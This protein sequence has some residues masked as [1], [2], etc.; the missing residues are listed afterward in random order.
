MAG[1]GSLALISAYESTAAANSKYLL[2]FLKYHF[3]F[4]LLLS[5][6]HTTKCQPTSPSP[7]F[8]RTPTSPK[9]L[10]LNEAPSGC[11]AHLHKYSDAQSKCAFL[12]SEMECSPQGFIDY[13][14]IFYC[15]CGDHLV[16]GYLALIAWL[17][18]LF[19]L[20]GNTASYYFCSS[21]E[22][23]SRLLRLPPTIAGVTLLA[24]GN[25]AP[26]V[27]ASIVSFV[28]PV[29]MG[30]VGLNSVLGGGF[31][32][33]SALVGIISILLGPR[34]IA[35]DKPSFL[36]DVC[37]YIAALCWLLVILI[38]GQINIWGAMAFA[39]LY[40]LYVFIVSVPYFCRRTDRVVKKVLGV[41]SP[42]LPIEPLLSPVGVD[43]ENPK[44]L[45]GAA[46][47]TSGISNEDEGVLFK[48]GCCF[49]FNQSPLSDNFRWF[50]WLVEMPLYLPRRLTIPDVSEE[51]WSKPFAVISVAS[52]PVLLAALW[53]T[54]GGDLGTKGIS[55]L[56]YLIG[57]LVG[58]ILGVAALFTTDSHGPPQRCLF[59]WLA[60][61]FLMSVVWTYIIAEELVA[62]LVSVGDIL[63]VSPAILGLTV[64]AWGNSLGDLTANVAMSVKDGPDGAQVAIAG[65]YAGPIFNTLVGLG[66]SLVLS[67]WHVHPSPFV[68]PKD[69]S[70]FQTL[71]FMLGGLLWALVIVPKKG[72]RLDRVLGGGLLAIYLCFLSLRL[73]QTLGLV[74]LQGPH[75]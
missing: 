35:I 1:G 52:A 27:F 70:L 50:L 57:G 23:L 67:A 74:K 46:K 42:V 63:G 8:R 53:N 30:D 47:Q 73:L 44:I 56:I 51:R 38:V 13:L 12:Q 15:I 59:P 33:S 31:F 6:V 40:M 39:S 34:G 61:G 24:L 58:L 65:C 49:G 71:G 69:I 11:T 5:F 66:M 17:L 41:A 25:G 22:S 7:L 16:L 64:L 54:Q 2:V 45:L 36:R 10:I 20:L 18:L 32:V 28:G 43:E 14:Q 4:L 68:I 55:L 3:S 60:G 19:Y 75:S 48:R 26:D 29:S 37:F 72:M 9:P 62:L 21:L